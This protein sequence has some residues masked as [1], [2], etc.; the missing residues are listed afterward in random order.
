MSFDSAAGHVTYT[1]HFWHIPQLHATRPDGDVDLDYSNYELTQDYH[2]LIDSRL[3]PRDALPLIAPDKG[4]WLDEFSFSKSPEVHAE[5]WGCWL[6]PARVATT[7]YVRASNFAAR[8]QKVSSFRAGVD[9]TNMVLTVHNMT[10][11]NA[12]CQVACPWGQIDILRENSPDDEFCR[13]G[14]PGPRARGAGQSH[15]RFFNV[16]RFD[17]P[18]SV[19]ASGS[20][21]LTNAAAVDM[22]FL[23]GAGRL[24]YLELLAQRVNGQVDYVGNRISITNIWANLYG[25]GTL[26]GWLLFVWP[27]PD[28]PLFHANF[29]AQNITLPMLVFGFTGKTN[30][31]EGR[32]DADL[33]VAGP[34]GLN[35]EGWNG[36]GRVHVHDALLW[37]FKI[38]GLLSPVLNLFSPGWGYSR[39]RDATADFTI[40]NGTIASRDVEILCQGFHLNMRG[41]VDAHSRINARAEAVLS[42]AVPLF[43]PILSLAFTP[44]SKLFEYHITG[45]LRDPAMDPVLYQSSSCICCIHSKAGNRL[46]PPR[47]HQAG[48]SSEDSDHERLGRRLSLF[49]VMAI[50]LSGSAT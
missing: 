21:S 6:P 42:K 33:D 4:H 20:F 27:T 48:A 5:V 16:F 14:G 10:L 47:M 38:F 31:L 2:F 32:L 34:Y 1:N 25:N 24:H 29:N 40:T 44:F 15:A 30:K 11:S 18:P 26:L 36:Q 43:G 46:P 9:F 17:T 8:G 50:F 41:T 12:Q 39:A 7:G 19:S 13:L 35:R 28:S 49:G 37:D 3:D 22:H 45:T 23:V